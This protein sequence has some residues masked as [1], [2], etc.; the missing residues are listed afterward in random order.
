MAALNGFINDGLFIGQSPKFFA[1]LTEL[2]QAA[3]AARH[4]ERDDDDDKNASTEASA[5]GTHTLTVINGS[6]SGRYEADT[7][8]IKVTADPPPPGKK[9]SRW[10]GDT[11]ILASPEDSTTTAT[12][13]SM[14]VTIEATYVDKGKK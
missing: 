11:E 6:G 13:T 1:L 8:E 3:D 10:I 4:G 7:S 9:F 2:A 14:D 5:P 12:I